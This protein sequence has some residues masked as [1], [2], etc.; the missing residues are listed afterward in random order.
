VH[1][2][3]VRLP[4]SLGGLRRDCVTRPLS[5]WMLLDDELH[6]DGV[7]G[8]SNVRAS[9]WRG[10]LDVRPSFLGESASASN[11]WVTLASNITVSNSFL[12]PWSLFS[13]LMESRRCYRF[14]LVLFC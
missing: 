2:L 3:G 13:K 9:L 11:P 1:H 8:G 5:V 10:G 14:F 7:C 12:Q 4:V 6:R